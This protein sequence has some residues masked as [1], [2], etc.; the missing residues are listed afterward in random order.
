MYGAHGEGRAQQMKY[1]LERTD[2]AIA[3]LEERRKHIDTTLAELRLIN[4]AVRRGLG[5][6]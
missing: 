1:V 5:T 4:A 2:D 3:E 6:K